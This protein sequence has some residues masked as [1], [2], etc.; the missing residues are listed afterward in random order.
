[1]LSYFLEETITNTTQGFWLLLT[2]IVS[3]VAIQVGIKFDAMF[4]QS[5]KAARVEKFESKRKNHRNAEKRKAI[6]RKRR[7]DHIRECQK[8]SE[9]KDRKESKKIL[10]NSQLGEEEE[11]YNDVKNFLGNAKTF[12]AD[13][14]QKVKPLISNN[15]SFEKYYTIFG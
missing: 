10:Y 11:F 8:H 4:S 2:M 6:E 15:F 13:A 9:K 12:T 7:F 5:G 1:M 14:W 3:V